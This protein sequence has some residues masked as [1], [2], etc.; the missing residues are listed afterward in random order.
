MHTRVIES[1]YVKFDI[2][3]EKRKIVMMTRLTGLKIDEFF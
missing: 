1:F 3:S 2:D